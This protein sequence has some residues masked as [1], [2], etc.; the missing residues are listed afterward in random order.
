MS[1]GTEAQRDHIIENLERLNARVAAQ[2]SARYVF[3]NG[4]IYG[5]GFMIGSTI[6]T[7]LLVSFIF[8][9]FG[10]TLFAAVIR[11]IAETLR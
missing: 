2:M 1:E 6:L 10:D 3:R 9:F 11:W 8:Q 4:I 7:A 5:F